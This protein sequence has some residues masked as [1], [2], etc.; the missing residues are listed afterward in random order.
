MRKDFPPGC[1]TLSLD[2]RHIPTDRDDAEDP[3]SPCISVC[4]LDE[5]DIC[6]GCFR[7]ANEI[8]AWMG[9]SAADKRDVIMRCQQRMA[10]HYGWSQSE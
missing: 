1:R 6:L 10:S 9:Y 5:Q 3:P 8:A 4:V 2:N 7:S